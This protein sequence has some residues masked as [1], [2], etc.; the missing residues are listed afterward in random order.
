M[1]IEEDGREKGVEKDGLLMMDSSVFPYDVAAAGVGSQ[2]QRR[3]RNT[4]A[5]DFVGH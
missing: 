5:L 2:A 3:M 4:P 1:I